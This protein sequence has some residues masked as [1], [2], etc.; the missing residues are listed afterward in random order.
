M[1]LNDNY[2]IQDFSGPEIVQDTICILNGFK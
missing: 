2:P 1:T